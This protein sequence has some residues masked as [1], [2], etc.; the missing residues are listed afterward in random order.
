M[1]YGDPE[2]TVE[3]PCPVCGS[4]EVFSD[5]AAPGEREQPVMLRCCFCHGERTDLEFYEE[6]A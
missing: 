3:A 2:M 6:A 5:L 1:S 4:R